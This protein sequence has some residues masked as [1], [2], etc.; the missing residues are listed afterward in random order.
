[1]TIKELKEIL[2]TYPDD[3]LVVTQSN[4]YEYR[5]IQKFD[6]TEL[7]LFSREGENPYILFPSFSPEDRDADVDEFKVITLTRL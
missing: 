6:F 4:T 2:E 3:L 1:M 5:A 7:N